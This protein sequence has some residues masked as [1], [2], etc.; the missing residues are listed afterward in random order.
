MSGR[1]TAN[2]EDSS[3]A[4]KRQTKDNGNDDVSRRDSASSTF[5]FPMH[6]KLDQLERDFGAEMKTLS[7]QFERTVLLLHPATL[8]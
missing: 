5:H 1:C 2:R 6:P 3:P 4:A 8:L 7:G